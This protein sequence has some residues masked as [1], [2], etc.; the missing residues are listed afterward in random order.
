MLILA[1][2]VSSMPGE[3]IVFFLLGTVFSDKIHG[4]AN[5]F[6]WFFFSFFKKTKQMRVIW[7]VSYIYYLHAPSKHPVL[8]SRASETSHIP[9]EIPLYSQLDSQSTH[10]HRF[11]MRIINLNIQ[12]YSNACYFISCQLT[13]SIPSVL[14]TIQSTRCTTQILCPIFRRWIWTKYYKM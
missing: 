14:A 5:R 1:L 7:G 3:F 6:R 12:C 8:G 13:R 11:H 4:S 9:T 2:I 10:M